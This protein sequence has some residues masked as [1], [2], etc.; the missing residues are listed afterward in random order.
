MFESTYAQLLREAGLTVEF[1][2]R[3]THD[4][5]A[6]GILKDTI[7]KQDKIKV[8]L[9]EVSA[10]TVCDNPH[11]VQFESTD[12]STACI[13]G[14]N[15]TSGEMDA[16]LVE[17]EMPMTVLDLVGEFET[18]F[19]NCSSQLYY[20]VLKEREMID[21]TM[22]GYPERG[23]VPLSDSIVFEYH[24]ELQRQ[25]RARGY[26][27][28]RFPVSMVMDEALS[29]VIHRTERNLFKEWVESHEWDGTPRLRTVFTDYLGA[30]APALRSR[31][32]LQ[33]SEEKAYLGGVAQA[34][35]LG[36]IARMYAPCQH[37]IVPV[38]IGP[39]GIGKGAALRFLAGSNEWFAAT[40]ADVTHLDRFLDSVGGA[41]IVEMGESAQIRNRSTQED[42]KAF[43]SKSEDRLRKAYARH[44]EVFP[45]HFILAATS[46]D[47]EVF[48]DPTGSRR[49]YPM[50]CDPSM[51]TKWIPI[52]ERIPE[53]QH[54]VEQ[55]WAEALA[56]YRAGVRPNMSK[57]VNQLARILQK[58]ATEVDL[59]V[60][61]L[62]EWID[63]MPLYTM[64][65]ARICRETIMKEYFQVEDMRDLRPMYASV[66]KRW[67]KST[68]KWERS[69]VTL[70]VNG[71]VSHSGFVRIDNL[72]EEKHEIETLM[73]AYED[74]KSGA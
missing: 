70:R 73:L 6:Y 23:I 52:N 12:G 45:R 24:L 42:L 72:G 63:S 13:P 34:W 60:K 26:K 29:I 17:R 71:K 3:V 31:P 64:R 56:L 41:V 50:D 30:T 48:T 8:D 21:M 47:R 19:P 37:D 20:D 25:L 40:T 61:A 5:F 39:Q 4:G 69:K 53:M 35:F 7:L 10:I 59:E 27:G 28:K 43:I 9:K 2:G 44:D 51:C 1:D 65:G 36:A 55:I 11:M 57:E 32:D 67:A 68:D 14:K 66:W 58:D 74:P 38:F 49:F 46:N 18:L 33:S 54:D 22:L 16:N 62:D 15:L